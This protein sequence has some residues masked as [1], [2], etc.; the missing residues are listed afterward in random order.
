MIRQLAESVA[1]ASQ[2][3]AQ[4]VASTGQQAI[5]MEQIRQAVSSIHEATQQN[6]SSSKQTEQ[7]ASDLSRLGNELVIMVGGEPQRQAIRA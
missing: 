5:G 1:Q 4:I 2:A 7:A 6:L 3:A